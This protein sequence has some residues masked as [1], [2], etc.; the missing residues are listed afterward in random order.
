LNHG[1]ARV[2]EP[3]I[4]TRSEQEENDKVDRYDEVN[5]PVDG[6]GHSR[7][8]AVVITIQ[9]DEHPYDVSVKCHEESFNPQGLFRVI[10]GNNMHHF[11]QPIQP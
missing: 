1:E 9:G 8:H 11:Y 5:N 3:S 6:Y 7:K 4:Q 10:L 2:F